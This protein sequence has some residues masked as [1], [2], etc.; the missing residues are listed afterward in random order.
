[1]GRRQAG[2]LDGLPQGFSVSHLAPHSE[3]ATV[4]GFPAGPS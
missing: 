4:I 2:I 1:M 3:F